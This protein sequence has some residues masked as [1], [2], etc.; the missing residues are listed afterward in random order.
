LS[1]D[2]NKEKALLTKRPYKISDFRFQISEL[3]FELR[4]SVVGRH[5]R[6]TEQNGGGTQIEGQTSSTPRP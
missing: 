6:R 4:T 5:K 3:I 1:E 2:L